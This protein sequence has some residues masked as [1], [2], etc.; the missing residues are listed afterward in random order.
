VL[1]Q[2]DTVV[3][4]SG[5]DQAGGCSVAARA[6]RIDDVGID[7][8]SNNGKGDINPCQRRRSGDDPVTS[9]EKPP[10]RSCGKRFK[11]YL[12]DES[13]W[14]NQT[15][16]YVDRIREEQDRRKSEF[17]LYDAEWRR[18]KNKLRWA[19]DQ[20]VYFQIQDSITYADIRKT[21]DIA[22]KAMVRFD[23]YMLRLLEHNKDSNGKMAELL[24]AT[25]LYI[26]D[27]GAQEEKATQQLKNMHS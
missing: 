14:R 2:V 12:K 19:Q 11:V 26:Q 27:C 15:L 16:E 23:A 4:I 6:S 20:L 13:L 8:M 10:R 24:E 18:L 9:K 22:K 3:E 7:S 5:N 25:R 17:D 21:F 1:I